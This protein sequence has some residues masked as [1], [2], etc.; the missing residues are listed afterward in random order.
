M[1]LFKKKGIFKS[2]RSHTLFLKKV[3]KKSAE[4]SIDENKA[5]GLSITYLEDGIIYEEDAKG[6]K[7]EIGRI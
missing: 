4:R 1:A 3:G 7:T 5:L 6:K 2:N